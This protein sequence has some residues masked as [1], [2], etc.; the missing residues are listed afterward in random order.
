M[1]NRNGLFYR[2]DI[3]SVDFETSISLACFNAIALLKYT[4][5][6]NLIII[7]IKRMLKFANSRAIAF[8]KMFH[9]LLPG[10]STTKSA[11]KPI[12]S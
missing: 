10:F 2:Y 8:T 5:L 9:Y 12:S 4:Q 7:K 11:D 6:L 1:Y 3:N